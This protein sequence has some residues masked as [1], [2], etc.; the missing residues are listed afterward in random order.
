MLKK[1]ELCNGKLIDSENENTNI[2]LYINP[3]EAER[4]HLVDD[5]LLDAH[6]L[7][8]ALDPNELGRLEFEQN[9]V[10]LI[11]KSPRSY[12]SE[13]NFLFKVHSIGLFLFAD[14]LVVVLAEE[15]PVFEG[16]RFI[17]INSLKDLVLKS[18][19]N[20]IIHFE[21]HLKVI[22][23]CSDDLE[24]KINT[25]MQN[26]ELLN[27]FTLEKSLV[28]YLNA[29]GSNGRVIEKLR[30]NS[31]KIGL[32]GEDI[33]LLEDTSI[34]NAQCYEQAQTYSQVLSG[35]MDARVSVV[36]NN[37]NL[38]MKS[39]TIVMIALM[40]PNLFVSFF[41]MNVHIPF[42][43]A[44]WMFWCILGVSNLLLVAIFIIQKYK[45]W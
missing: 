17:R 9:H 44:R 37:L 16:R 24:G 18:I 33:E 12:R 41:S 13:D 27:M 30:M 39:L 40:L 5:L 29:I 21:D 36:S 38:L 42:Q 35:L 8:S 45:R 28:Y 10:A 2:L 6:T 31:A 43:E 23:M 19:F 20:A 26:K 14:K 11:V 34:E 15:I 25:S 3:D 22:N 32:T 4:K 7:M 1:K